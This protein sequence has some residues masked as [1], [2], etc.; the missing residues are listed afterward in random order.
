MVVPAVV[1]ISNYWSDALKVFET[2]AVWMR[3]NV[4]QNFPFTAMSTQS[5]LPQNY[6]NK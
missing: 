3:R 4:M 6:L 2:L 1:D 5:P